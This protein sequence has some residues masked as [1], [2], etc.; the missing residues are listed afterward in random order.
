MPKVVQRPATVLRTYI[1]GDAHL[2]GVCKVGL[3]SVAVSLPPQVGEGD[4]VVLRGWGSS[5]TVAQAKP[6]WRQGAR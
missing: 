6:H 2:M 5:W 1:N 4:R 3:R